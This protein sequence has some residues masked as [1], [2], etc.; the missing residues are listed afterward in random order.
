LAQPRFGPALAHKI[1]A[2][3][4]GKRVFHTLDGLRGIAALG[5]LLFHGSYFFA[6]LAAPGGYLAVDLFFMMSGVVVAHAYEGRFRAGMRTLEFM[7]V[8]FIRLYPV[9]LLGTVLG[10]AM[11]VASLHGNN[12]VGWDSRSL[13]LAALLALLFLPNPSSRPVDQLYPL[14]IPCWSL[15]FEVLINFLF[16]ICW[17]ALSSRRLA[18]VCAATGLAV[19]LL[20]AR[21]GNLDQGSDLAGFFA[22]VV[23][24]VFGFSVGILI[25][26]QVRA[27]QRESNIAFLAIAGLVIV[28]IAGAPPAGWRALWDA[29]AVLVLFP[30]LVYWGTLVDPS[31]WLK[32][33]ATFLGVTSYAVYVLHSPLSA[34]LH[35][36]ARHLG[37]G[38]AS[39]APSAPYLGAAMVA[40][41]L[42]LCWLVDRYF[43]A[44]VRRLLGRIL[45]RI[46]NPS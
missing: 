34:G 20:I 43:D 41:L 24:T 18:A 13:M 45:P 40:I 30:L 12:S 32:S 39:V 23:R 7:R 26:R 6:P 14:N 5:V 22:G 21:H 4:S 31:A 35:S 11:A 42:P 16:A 44:P 3:L 8:R 38:A 10:A 37:G 27:P 28:A 9:Y 17:R 29:V 46:P 33:V 36:L 1:E 2:D 15:F 25:A 19:C